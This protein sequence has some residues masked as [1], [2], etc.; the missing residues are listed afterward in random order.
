MENTGTIVTFWPLFDYRQSPRD[1]YSNLSI[2]GPLF[3]FQQ[4]GNERQMALRPL[5]YET[6]NLN[7]QTASINYLYPLASQET[8]PE[9]STF[10]FLKLIQ[11]NTFRKNEPEGQ[12]KESMFFPFYISGNSSKYGPYRSFFPFYG[13]IYE[14]FWRD[15]YHFALFPIYG[16][17]VKNGTTTR[18][19][20]YP[21][22]ST[23][24]GDRESGFKVWPLYGQS[25]KERVYDKRFA[26]WPFFLHSS[27]VG[28]NTENP[29][30]QF[31]ILPLYVATD[32]P[33]RVS[34][35]FL[36]PFFGYSDEL[37]HDQHQVD[38]LWPFWLTV[39]GSSK[40]ETRI[41]PFFSE[42]KR[43]ENLKRWYMWPLLKHEEINSSS[44]RQE[45]DRILFFLYNDNRET[46]PKDGSDRRRTAL[47]PLFVYKSDTR[48]VKSLTIP[49][50][51]EPIFDREG[52][53]KNW[54]PLWRFYQ[55]RWA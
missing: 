4:Q 8:S 45:L 42:E 50:P 5:F 9:V 40:N 24:E 23:T 44:Y 22:F 25:A 28:L 30:H 3:K 53:E 1:G 32:S 46:W 43:K 7:S 20:L 33:Q 55:Q 26:L 29:T 31:S 12:Q 41:L 36:W 27:I 47:W 11:S 19:Y 51:V 35:S 18:N 17:T 13:D 39:R 15:E 49:A 2:L 21:F 52:I 6:A 34:R 37:L 16:R 14:R 38:Y 54:A 10:Q 48:G